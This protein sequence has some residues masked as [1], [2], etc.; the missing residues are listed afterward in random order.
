MYCLHGTAWSD[1]PAVWVSMVQC[2]RVTGCHQ[3]RPPLQQSSDSCKD[4]PPGTVDIQT[5]HWN[6]ALN[7]SGS[8]RPDL[9]RLFTGIKT[10]LSNTNNAHATQHQSKAEISRRLL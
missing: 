4:S 8:A 6:F 1:W 7:H 10:Q 2:G 9:F 5:G 3:L